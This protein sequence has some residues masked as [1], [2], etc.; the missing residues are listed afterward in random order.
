MLLTPICRRHP[1]FHDNRL[2]TSPTCTQT[3]I[4]MIKEVFDSLCHTGSTSI[5]KRLK[6]TKQTTMCSLLVPLSK[7]SKWGYP[8]YPLFCSGPLPVFPCKAPLHRDGCENQCGA[9]GCA[10][11]RNE[12]SG[13]GHLQGFWDDIGPNRPNNVVSGVI[14]DFGSCIWRVVAL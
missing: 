3:P 5:S 1:S 11:A 7:Q 12:G 4:Q 2:L 13:D 6:W 10:M 9:I 8:T 14:H